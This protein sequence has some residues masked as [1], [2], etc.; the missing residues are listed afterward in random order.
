MTGKL[1]AFEGI[2]GSGKSTQVSLV[3][4]ALLQRGLDVVCLRE[5][6]SGPIGSKIRAAAAAGTLPDPYRLTDLFT[7]DRAYNVRSNI[8]PALAAGKIILLDRYFYSTAA[9]QGAKGVSVEH[10]L[11]RNRAFAPEPDLLVYLHLEP[12]EA[13]VRMDRELDQ[14]EDLD[15]QRRV[16]KTYGLIIGDIMRAD[17]AS[18]WSDDEDLFVAMR[19]RRDALA[20]HRTVYIPANWPQDKI[21]STVVENLLALGV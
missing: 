20:P 12:E 16:A 10:I 15:L 5:P 19:H 6:T 18:W 7:E 2:D 4:A 17:G 13:A 14:F 9:Y 3:E 8:E 1:I 11:K 21:C